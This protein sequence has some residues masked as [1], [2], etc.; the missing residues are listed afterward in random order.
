[1]EA[2]AVQPGGPAE[3]EALP[4]KEGLRDD[5]KADDV[6]EAEP[7]DARRVPI[8]LLLQKLRDVRQLRAQDGIGPPVDRLHG[9]GF[10]QVL[11]EKLPGEGAVRQG[12][13][14]VLLQDVQLVDGDPG[15]GAGVADDNQLVLPVV[16]Q[17]E[18]VE[19][20]EDLLG[21]QPGPVELRQTVPPADEGLVPLEAVESGVHLRQ[22]RRQHREVVVRERAQGRDIR[23]LVSSCRGPALRDLSG[24]GELRQR[25]QRGKRGGL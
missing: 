6:P 13:V 22:L 1:M 18:A 14:G 23:Q 15:P 4:V 8:L 25:G 10:A 19:P 12:P 2:F 17:I 7:F 16:V 11:S 24:G 3:A 21:R 5:L 9:H 20:G